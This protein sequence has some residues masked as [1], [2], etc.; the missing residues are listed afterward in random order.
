MNS[1]QAESLASKFEIQMPVVVLAKMKSG[2]VEDWKRLDEVW[3]LVGDKPAF[4]RYVRDEIKRFIAGDKQPTPAAPTVSRPAIPLPD[5]KTSDPAAPEGS[6]WL[7]PF[8][9]KDFVFFVFFPQ[10]D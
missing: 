2:Q 4:A 10:G 8:P 3:A 9:S 7:F 1:Q 6:H 5:A